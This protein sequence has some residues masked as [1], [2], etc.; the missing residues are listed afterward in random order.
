MSSFGLSGTN[1]HVI[2]EEAVPVE[3]EA[4]ERL[5]LPVAPVVVSGK[6]PAALEAQIG[7]FGELVANGDPLDVAY[8]AATGRA[9]LEHRAVLVGP[10]TV[11]GS[12]T[13]GKV[14]FLFTGQGS[15]RLG[16]GRELYETFPVFAG[17]FDEVCAVLDPA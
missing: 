15:Q 13:E 4:V 1:A 11:I 16:M 17:A 14:A 8:S 2:V 10:E 7:R 12:V 5:E 6:T 3:E 9:V